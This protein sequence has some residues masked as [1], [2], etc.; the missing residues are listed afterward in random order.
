MAIRHCAR[1][2]VETLERIGAQVRDINVRPP[3]EVL[4]QSPIADM[5]ARCGSPRGIPP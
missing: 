4:N 5:N 3:E 2:E 1:A